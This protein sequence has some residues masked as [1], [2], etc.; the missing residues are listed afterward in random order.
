MTDSPLPKTR[1]TILT[2]AGTLVAGTTTAGA[3]NKSESSSSSSGNDSNS[4]PPVEDPDEIETSSVEDDTMDA[5]RFVHLAPDVGDI[6]IQVNGG[7]EWPTAQQFHK[8]EYEAHMPEE[9]YTVTVTPTDADG[10]EPLITN[11]VTLG[12]GAHTLALVGERCAVSNHSLDLVTITDDYSGIETD[13]ARIQFIHAGTDAP[14]IDLLRKDGTLMLEGLDFGTADTVDIP[15][16][17]GKQVVLLAESGTTTQ[18]SKVPITP[19]PGEAHTAFVVGY[20]EPQSAPSSVAEP[21]PLTLGFDTTAPP[22]K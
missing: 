4:Q 2:S 18:L 14:S 13:K 19:T 7:A 1:R 9:T 8:S 3:A 16:D 10:G 22:S 20:T 6:D 15:A 12:P 11:D 5:T 17:G 21:L